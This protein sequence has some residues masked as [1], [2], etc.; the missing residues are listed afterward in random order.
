MRKRCLSFLLALA[1]I[2]ALPEMN[3]SAEKSVPEASVV[4][5]ESDSR[6]LPTG[7][8]AEITAS[9]VTDSGYSVVEGDTSIG[10]LSEVSYDDKPCYACLND[11]EKSVY[12]A[13]MEASQFTSSDQFAAV[14]ALQATYDEC[15]IAYC[16][17]KSDNPDLFWVGSGYSYAYAGDTDYIRSVAFS[18]VRPADYETK[19][20]AFDDAVSSFLTGIDMTEPPAAVAMKIHDKLIANVVYDTATADNTTGA[21]DLSHSAYNALVKNK[22]VCDGYSY[23]YEFL[24]QKAGIESTTILGYAYSGESAGGHAWN[25]VHLNGSWYEVDSTWDD[26]A[27]AVFCHDYFNITTTAI[28]KE[29]TRYGTLYTDLLPK[30]EGT[31]F[32]YSYMAKCGTTLKSGIDSE[33]NTLLTALWKDGALS[34][35][36][37]GSHYSAWNLK[38]CSQTN[39]V[40]SASDDII[41]KAATAIPAGTLLVLDSDWTR[42]IPY[43][44]LSAPDQT[45]E[46]TNTLNISV[47]FDNGS[48]GSTAGQLV[49]GDISAAAAPV[50]TVQETASGKSFTISCTDA[51]ASVYYTTDGSEP[52]VSSTLYSGAVP[53]SRPVTVKAKAF[54]EGLAA[55]STASSS[56]EIPGVYVNE[57]N[58]PDASFREWITE[59]VSGADD[60]FLNNYELSHVT[61]A[62]VSYTSILDLS[63]IQ[64]FTALTSLD[65]RYDRLSGMDLRAN[66][67]L[68]K[69][70]GTVWIDAADRTCDPGAMFTG[71]ALNEITDL[72]G[73]TV[74][75]SSLTGLDA[76]V[77]VVFKSGGAVY[78]LNV[79]GENDW[80]SPLSASDRTAGETAPEPSAAAAF[81]NVEYVY[82]SAAD[83]TYTGDVP[84]EAGTWYVRAL[85]YETADYSGLYSDPVSF[86]I[87][88][89]AELPFTDVR[90]G[91]WYY[92]YIQYVYD[93]KIMTGLSSTIFGPEN[94]LPR[95]QFAVILYRMEGSPA[96]AYSPKF[97]D[98]SKGAFYASAV[99]WASEKGIVSGYGNGKFGPADVITREQIMAMMYRYAV[100]CK[101]YDMSEVN[102]LSSFPDRAKVSSFA[103][104]AVMWAVGAGLV[105]G[106]HN[107]INPQGSATRAQCAAIIVRFLTHSWKSKT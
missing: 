85:V 37:T 38:L 59:H 47:E 99:L 9:D 82:S 14:S 75:G 54:A 23:A 15:V 41:W 55:S 72:S 29:H 32:Q 28:S 36:S 74:G 4:R 19:K 45:A 63:G 12:R 62:D 101:G 104:S 34:D 18:N 16:A 96:V 60:G 17:V 20:K 90:S 5:D 64:Y 57:D 42:S 11:N 87:K 49:K 93:H 44:S 91:A 7:D 27:Y 65:C 81:G 40:Y 107:N 1:M 94:S 46:G 26:Q 33:G 88:K 92:N 79:Y 13:F 76:G 78:T 56:I 39:G 68:T 43:I 86:V 89:A 84:Q 102:D 106:D 69:V 52:S 67:A 73:A 3:V 95:A 6:F 24:L 71:L 21:D 50:I 66:T 80:T 30:A 22:A 10:A 8:L 2:T 58:F 103:V 53:V 98:V 105:S 100:N 35:L 51:G 48:Y 25:M 83:G 70:Y 31:H 61:S 77:P 97:P